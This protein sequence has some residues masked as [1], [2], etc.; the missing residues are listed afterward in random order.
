VALV[1]LSSCGSDLFLLVDPRWEGCIVPE[2]VRNNDDVEELA[3]QASILAKQASSGHWRKRFLGEE[4]G[5]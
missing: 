1:A 3:G 2:G 5:S 4:C